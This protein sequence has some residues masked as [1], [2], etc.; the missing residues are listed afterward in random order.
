MSSEY[1]KKYWWVVGIVVPIVVALIPVTIIFLKPE[2][3]NEAMYISNP[4]YSGDMYFINLYGIENEYKETERDAV[5]E[6]SLKQ[7]IEHAVNL[8]KMSKYKDAIPIF[9]KVVQ[10]IPLPSIYSNLGVLFAIKKDYEAA[11]K[12]YNE[13]LQLD[14]GYQPVHRNLGLLEESQG[15][16]DDAL[17]H[18]KQ[19]PD[20]KDSQKLVQVVQK[21]KEKRQTTTSATTTS[22]Q[23]EVTQT[24]PTGITSDTNVI[25][26]ITVSPLLRQGLPD[27]EKI[28]I[29]EAGTNPLNSFYP[30]QEADTFG[31]P[32]IVNPGRYDIILKPVGGICFTLIA[33]V[34]LKEKRAV[35]VDPNVIVSYITVSPLTLKDFPPLKEVFLV[36]AG[37]DQDSTIHFLQ[38]T[39]NFGVPMLVN[40]GRY[41]IVCIPEE[42][43][44]FT[45]ARGVDVKTGQ[46]VAVD[47]NR[48]A[49]AFVCKD[50]E[51]PGLNLESIL[52]VKAGTS[53]KGGF[54]V[55]QKSNGFG[56]PMMIYAGDFYD[57]LLKPVAGVPVRL[58][59][60]V[61]PKAGRITYIGGR[62]D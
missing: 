49:A 8:V 44:Y 12:A 5:M 25:S 39:E 7:K 59:E 54:G 43:N 40:P 32:M 13:T 20:L 27:I 57:I 56:K 11:R 19:A 17:K 24:Q 14:P 62:S 4:E 26:S 18:L 51:I 23:P 34:D 61:S 47:A 9:E 30:V 52:V 55:L 48:E 36:A 1:P 58:D 46:G 38:R 3:V 31:K 22:S 28:F 53:L 50:P 42:G 45:L 15:R 35:E 29:V 21:K 37:T 16:F 60:N 6:Q 33:N 41:D 2:K 10:S